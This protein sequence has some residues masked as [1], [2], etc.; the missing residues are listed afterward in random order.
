MKK[1]KTIFFVSGIAVICIVLII[2]LAFSLFFINHFY[3]GTVIGEVDCGGKTPVEAEALLAEQVG[4]YTLKIQG[5]EEMEALLTATE[6]ELQFMPGNAF[7]EIA[8]AQNG[9]GWIACLWKNLHYR[10]PMIVEFDEKLLESRIGQLLMM[11]E[12]NMR[13][14]RSAYI[15]D[16]DE[17]TG[18]YPMIEEDN[19][20]YLFYDN[21]KKAVMQA[22]RNMEHTLVLEDA[23]CYERPEFTQNDTELCRFQARLNRYVSAQIVYDWH[24]FEETV[25]GEEI[26]QWL[27]VDRER[28]WAGIDAQAVREYVNNLSRKYDTYGKIRQF[29]THQG[30]QIYVEPGNYGWQVNRKKETER[31]I[32][33]IRSGRCEEREP[34]YLFT[35]NEKGEDDIGSSYVEIDL[36]NQCL[37]LY[38]EGQLVTETDFVSGNV[39]R[40]FTTPNGIYGLTYKTQNATLKGQGYQTPVKYW[41]PFNGNIGM[42]DA[43][44]RREFGGDIYL[45]S[46]SHGCI[47]LPPKEAETI[48]E[49]VYKGFPVICYTAEKEENHEQN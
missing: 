11:Q 48:Y 45:K 26:H 20:T 34:E 43:N 36:G 33:A 42:H 46:G 7:L 21:V 38:S 15:G 4:T 49:Y 25:D 3:F 31:L 35:A 6:I 40:G 8:K 12:K 2:Y 39:S 13:R 28:L 22:V 1:K 27:N 16:Y 10:V 41:M 17:K 24:G 18:Q 30:K 29:T 9:F 5:R 19:G 44:W 23:D 47:N 37:Y 14:P 32:K